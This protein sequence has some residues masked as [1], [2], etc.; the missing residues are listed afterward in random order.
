MESR[1]SPKN[2]ESKLSS[3]NIFIHQKLTFMLATYPFPLLTPTP[4]PLLWCSGNMN[5]LCWPDL[6]VCIL[7]QLL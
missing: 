4:K 1:L 3:K 2:M 7:N 6:Y 5:S